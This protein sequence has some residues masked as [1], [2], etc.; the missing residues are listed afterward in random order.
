MEVDLDERTV[1]TRPLDSLVISYQVVPIP[2]INSAEATA[3]LAQF[4]KRHS[5]PLRIDRRHRVVIVPDRLV[6]ELR[7]LI[8]DSTAVAGVQVGEPALGCIVRC[9][10][11]E[12]PTLTQQ[13]I[14]V[15]HEDGHSTTGKLCCTCQEES[16]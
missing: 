9:N 3:V 12:R 6:D 5:V 16:L 4:R 13:Q 11:P 7:M 15:Y 8:Q 1:L 10:D 14:P 2:H